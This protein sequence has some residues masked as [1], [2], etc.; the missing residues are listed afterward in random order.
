MPKV[1]RKN[2][3]R[4]SKRRRHEA[5]TIRGTEDLK[6]FDEWTTIFA[7]SCVLVNDGML[8]PRVPLHEKSRES[9]LDGMGKARAS[10]A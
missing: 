3:K 10:T 7:A 1:L 5:L 6:N 8:L 4:L 9:T 2:A